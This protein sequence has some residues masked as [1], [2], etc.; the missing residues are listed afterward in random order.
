MIHYISPYSVDKNIGGA[1]NSAITQLNA[2]DEDW[3]VHLD[4][5]AMWLLPDSKARLEAIL[6][7]TDYDMLGA[8][9]NRL[10]YNDQLTTGMFDE[11][12]IRK[13]IGH[14][15]LHWEIYGESTMIYNGILAA[16]CLCFRVSTWRKL[17]GFE[18]NSLQFDSLFSIKARAIGMKIGLMPGIYV[19]HAYRMWSDN[20]AM[21]I[22]HL[23]QE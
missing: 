17:G 11:Y 12:D 6:S 7:T 18:E 13:H 10:A 1:I 14:A 19:F 4:Q 9:T 20:P 16:F 8:V 22:K 3:I 2:A 23:S 5:D 15:K 21:D